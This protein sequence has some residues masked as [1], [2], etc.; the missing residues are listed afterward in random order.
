MAG[1]DKHAIGHAGKIEAARPA[2]ESIGTVSPRRCFQS[3]PGLGDYPHGPTR[4]REAL[5]LRQFP[6]RAFP[7]LVTRP[8]VASGLRKFR[9]LGTKTGVGGPGFRR[10][11][12]AFP[13][14]SLLQFLANA[15]KATSRV[16]P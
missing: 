14:H 16:A 12:G 8:S 5:G 2:G 7:L 13:A 3:A 10:H 4:A 15:C 9:P 11:P 1:T 6:P